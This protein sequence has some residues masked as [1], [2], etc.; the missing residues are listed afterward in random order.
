[1]DYKEMSQEHILPLLPLR[2]VV[3]FPYMIIPLFVGRERSVRA[4]E[5][6]TE[7]EGGRLMFATQKEAKIVNPMPD[8]IFDV[9]TIG[10]IVQMLKLPD[11]SV[12]VLVEGQQRA[13]VTEFLRVEDYFAV[14]AKEIPKNHIV[15][16]EVLALIRSVKVNF[17]RLAKLKKGI[18]TE[19]VDAMKDMEDPERIS[20]TLV[21]H[22][23]LKLEKKQQFLEEPSPLIRLEMLLEN[24]QAEIEIIHVER[25]INRRI[26]KQVEQTQKEFYLNEQMRAIQKELGEKGDYLNEIRELEEKINKKKMSKEAAKRAKEE[27]KKLKLIPCPP[28]PLW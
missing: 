13:R 4:L 20:D 11:G 16:P 19:V 2:E 3:L 10:T 21:G 9:G 8:D 6:A 14:R 26:K 27:L 1:M 24:I 23:E 22:L 17:E 15:N 18:P 25:K 12:K 28:R 5:I 7:R